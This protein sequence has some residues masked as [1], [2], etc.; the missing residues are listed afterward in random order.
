MTFSLYELLLIIGLTQG[1]ITSVL[2]VTTQK[3]KKSNRLLALGIFSFCLLSAKM[4][5]NSFGVSDTTAFRYIPIASQLAIPPLMYMYLISLLRPKAN[6]TWESM[7]QFIPFIF[8]QVFVIVVYFKVQGMASITQQDQAAELLMYGPIKLAE[9]YI[10]LLSIACYLGLGFIELKRYRQRVNE[11]VSDSTC[12][13]F[14][15]LLRVFVLS[16]ILGMFLLVNMAVEII[17]NLSDITLLHWQVYFV[18]ISF[19][20]YYLGFVGYKQPDFQLLPFV[21]ELKLDDEKNLNRLSDEQLSQIIETLETELLEKKAY[22]NPTLSSL[23][24]AKL[25]NISQSAL[26]FA[27]NKHYQKP[28]RKVIN[29]LRVE[30]VKSKLAQNL[31]AGHSILSIALDS[32]FNSEASF[33]RIFKKQEGLAPK[34]YLLKLS[35][36]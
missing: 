26:S 14:T 21:P 16:S 24:L 7:T 9:D 2:L 3:N 10:T 5:L 36:T 12:P 29:E 15:W 20:I 18:Y 34:A 32:G 19:L 17:F 27:I 23:D 6:L 22:L 30:E 4:V 31:E 1:T 28:F 35:A 25:L 8:V 11:T 33:Y 13:T